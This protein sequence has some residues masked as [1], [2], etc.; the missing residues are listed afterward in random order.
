[1]LHNGSQIIGRK[2][3]IRVLEVDEVDILMDVSGASP[4]MLEELKKTS[5]GMR[6]AILYLYL[7]FSPA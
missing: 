3:L 1:V 5:T 6:I 4:G 7:P 2:G